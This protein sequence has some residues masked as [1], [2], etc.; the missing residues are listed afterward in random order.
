MRNRNPRGLRHRLAAE[1]ARIIADRGF[2]DFDGARRKAA[3]RL[4]VTDRKL[5][6]DNAEIADELASYRALFQAD[7]QQL[8]QQR[9]RAVALEAMGLLEDFAPRLVGAVAEG[10]AGAH[11]PVMLHLTADSPKTVAISLLDQG[12]DYAADERQLKFPDGTLRSR[13]VIRFAHDDVEIRAVVLEPADRSRPPLDPV[14]GRPER[15][16]DARA[17]RELL[18]LQ[19]LSASST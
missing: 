10:S 14:S 8:I 7:E 1:A 18:S 12:L 9:L 16:M 2:A 6:P 15:G 19:P 17:L 13:P 3:E 4:R 11:S 5:W